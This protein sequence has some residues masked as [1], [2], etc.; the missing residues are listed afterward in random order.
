MPNNRPDRVSADR[1]GSWPW[2][3]LWPCE[4]MVALAACV[5]LVWTSDAR[6]VIL[7]STAT[8]NTTAPS[9][10]YGL[11]A[12]NLEGRTN[13]G[14]LGTPIASQYFIAAEHI[15]KVSSITVESQ[16]YT[17]TGY[18]D[19]PLTDL[20]I[21]KISGTFSSYA[22]LYNSAIDGSEVGKTITVFGRGTQR[23]SEVTVD[24]ELKGWQWGT[25]DGRK[26]W[27]PKRCQQ[28]GRLLHFNPSGVRFQ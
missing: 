21:Y 1:S 5:L 13:N 3:C 16:T 10:D 12:W 25:A 17:V 24:G 9:S 6:G 14:F 2:L 22:T 15:G 23:G 8:L 4:A 27:G 7:Y 26:S 20:R 18:V 19:D 28:R 11:D